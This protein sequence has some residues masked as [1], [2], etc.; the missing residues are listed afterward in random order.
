MVAEEGA[1]LLLEH[2]PEG[3]LLQDKVRDGE[4]KLES[5]EPIVVTPLAVEG[6]E[7]QRVS[8]RW[9]VEVREL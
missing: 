4:G 7:G 6:V 8:P 5:Y 2:N 9:V 1:H 3:L